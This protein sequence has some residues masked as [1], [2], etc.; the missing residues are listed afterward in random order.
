M[1]A[2]VVL[3]VYKRYEHTERM[4]ESLANNYLAE[5]TE[6]FVFSDGAKKASDQDAVDR[7]RMLIDDPR[8]KERFKSVSV[9][10]ATSNKGLANS[11]INGVT[12]ILD[13]Y[14]KIIVVE[15]DLILSK[16]FLRFM[17]KALDY[18]ETVPDIWSISGYSFPMRALKKYPHDVFYSYRGCSWGWGTWKDR[19][20]RVDWEC[21]EYDAFIQ[22]PARIQKFNRGGRDMTPMLT[23]QMEGKIDSWA[24]RW[25]FAQ[26]NAEMYTVYPKNSLLKNEGFDGTG[27]HGG[28]FTDFRTDILEHGTE[29]LEILKIEPKIASEFWKKYSNTLDQKIMRRIKKYC[30]FLFGK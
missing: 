12:D 27:T 3:F 17:N 10:A 1:L 22:D 6:L 19:W 25:C 16:T 8:W 23:S 20:E 2:P 14:G 5:Q 30:G 11:V 18:Y 21:R 26:S 4:L 13:Q 15:D 9:V 28:S 7:V 24:I 29:K